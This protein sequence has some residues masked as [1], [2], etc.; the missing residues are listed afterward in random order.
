M[1]SCLAAWEERR[2]SALD[3]NFELE[4]FFVFGG[5]RISMQDRVAGFRFD[6]GGVGGAVFVMVVD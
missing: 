3:M 1:D 5:L 4:R 2:S 6:L